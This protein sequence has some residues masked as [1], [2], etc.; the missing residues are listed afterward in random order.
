MPISTIS[1]DLAGLRILARGRGVTVLV[2]RA[3]VDVHATCR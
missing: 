3:P 2:I 1:I